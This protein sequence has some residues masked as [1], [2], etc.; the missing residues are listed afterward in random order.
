MAFDG[1]KFAERT[2]VA[3]AYGF[4]EIVAIV[5]ERAVGH[6]GGRRLWRSGRQNAIATDNFIE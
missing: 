2:A 4:T 3:A 6:F 1:T 5:T